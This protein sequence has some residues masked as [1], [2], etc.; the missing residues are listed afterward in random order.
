MVKLVG[1]PREVG[2]RFGE[3]LAP[4]VRK[5]VEEYRRFCEKK[6]KADPVHTHAFLAVLDEAAPH[7]IEEHQGLAEAAGVDFL[8]LVNLNFA[9]PLTNIPSCTSVIAMGDRTVRGVPLLLKI[10]DERPQHQAMGYRRLEGTIGMLFGTDACNMGVGQGCNES[11]L[12]VA[13]NSGGL[14]PVRHVPPGF[15]DCHMMRLLLE[16]ARNVDE[17]LEIF[18]RLVEDRKVGLVD[19][20]R[21][22]IF[23]LADRRGKGLIIEATWDRFATRALDSGF[24][25]YSNHWLLEE[26]KPFTKPAEPENPLY[27]SSVVRLCRGRE[28]LEGK[29]RI[30]PADLE[31]FSRDEENPPFAICNGSDHFPW[32]TVSAF[33]YELDPDLRVPVRVAAGLPTRVEFE[34]VP[35]WA[36][37][38]PLS[39][40][41]EWKG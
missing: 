19:G 36:E 31:A 7:W 16:G 25:V 13:N 14:V 34:D 22:M 39:Y 35:L 4:F 40:L 21:G 12:A 3:V 24:A 27:R 38:T 41:Q 11:G 33:I 26:S 5:R 6:G 9:A 10:R 18:G 23:L 8:D 15:N 32:R 20:V 30:S 28:L 37:E 17:A 1:K 2:G 29:E